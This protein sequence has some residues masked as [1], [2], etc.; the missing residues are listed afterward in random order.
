MISIIFAISANNCIGKNNTKN[1]LPWDI[2]EDMAFFKKHT[3]AKTIIGGKNTYALMGRALPNRR[4]IMI[5]T[6]AVTSFTN[7]EVISD[8]AEIIKQ[9]KNSDEEIVVIGGK[10]LF[11]S[12]MEHVSRIYLTNIN[13]SFDG[14]TF[15]DNFTDHLNSFKVTETYPGLDPRLTF[16]IYDRNLK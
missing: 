15:Y 4:N 16:T 10:I 5:S 7:I 14:D 8:L 11:E 2:K 6:T 3:I 1:G 9:Y 13:E 12:I